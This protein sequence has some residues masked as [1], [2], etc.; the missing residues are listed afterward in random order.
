MCNSV[1]FYAYNTKKIFFP[2]IHTSTSNSKDHAPNNHRDLTTTRSR[3][4][5][6]L[7]LLG[8]AG[9]FG[10]QGWHLGGADGQQNCMSDIKVR[11]HELFL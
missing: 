7:D 8:G 9:P 11:H 5:A 2:S 3:P 1:E 4:N 6:H 10:L